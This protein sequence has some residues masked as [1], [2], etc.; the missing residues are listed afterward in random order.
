MSCTNV[1]YHIVF[2]T[3]ERRPWLTPEGLTQTCRYIGGIVRDLQGTLLDANGGADHLHLVA[4]VHPSV[5]VAAF[6]QGGQE[7][8]QQVDSQG[9][10]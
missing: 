1:P 4:V 8:R 6:P 5:A 10:R 2:S 9:V 7:R 3:K